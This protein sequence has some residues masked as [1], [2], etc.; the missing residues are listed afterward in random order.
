M[1]ASL[2]LLMPVVTPEYYTRAS[3]PNVDRTQATNEQQLQ[4]DN[5]RRF[6]V[7][8][9]QVGDYLFCRAMPMS[10]HR[11]HGESA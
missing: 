10:R 11:A 3:V 8:P 9:L 1:H 2:I 5:L 7:Q 4:D 6:G